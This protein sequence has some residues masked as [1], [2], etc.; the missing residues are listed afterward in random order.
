MCPPA[1]SAALAEAILELKRDEELRQ[2]IGWEG[3]NLFVNRCSVEK[4]G[5]SLKE[6]IAKTYEDL[7]G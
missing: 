6:I 2:R 4:I 5:Q 1:D 3:Y 7:P